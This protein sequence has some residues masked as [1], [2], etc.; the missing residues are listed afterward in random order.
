MS[1]FMI[2]TLI[3]H[4]K[5]IREII[6]EMVKDIILNT[7]RNIRKNNIK[8]II[9]VYRSKYPIVCFSKKM[10]LFDISIKKFLKEKMYF[11]KNVIKK[12][13]YGK[14][15]IKSLFLKIKKNPKKYID[16]NNIKK[17]N[18]DRSVCDFIAGM[19]DRFAI[20]L[21]NKSK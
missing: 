6:N 4:A 15:V 5:I 7:K 20:N 12:T 17:S 21:Y 9:D 8:N 1:L 19:T 3:S 18:I 2:S 10:N 14:I 13:N 11:H 16:I